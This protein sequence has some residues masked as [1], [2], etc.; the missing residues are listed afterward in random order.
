MQLE[1]ELRDKLQLLRDQANALLK[2][3][4]ANTSEYLVEVVRLHSA[5]PAFVVLVVVKFLPR[6]VAIVARR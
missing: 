2:H 4:T 1:T 3:T 5:N 6:P